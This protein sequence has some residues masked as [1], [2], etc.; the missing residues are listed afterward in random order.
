VTT[1]RAGNVEKAVRSELRRLGCSV[2]S[3]GSAALAVSLARQIDSS[4]G[5]VAAAAAAAQLRLLLA[6]LR[7]ASADARPKRSKL[8]DI[9]A[10]ELAARRAAAG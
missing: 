1:P 3:D 6:D 4:R 9:R 8:D 7:S 2:Q 10:D 5:A